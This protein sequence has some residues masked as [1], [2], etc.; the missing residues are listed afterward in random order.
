MESPGVIVGVTCDVGG[1]RLSGGPVPRS[2]VGRPTPASVTAAAPVASPMCMGQPHA[3]PGGQQL[4]LSLL[5]PHPRPLSVPLRPRLCVVC[6]CVC[7]SAG[8]PYRNRTYT[9]EYMS[10][11]SLP[12]PP[13]SRSCAGDAPPSSRE[14]TWP[15]PQPHSLR[16][17]GC[18]HLFPA[19]SHHLLHSGRLFPP[20]TGL[21]GDYVSTPSR[22]RRRPPEPVRSCALSAQDGPW[23]IVGPPQYLW[24]KQK[25]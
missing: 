6:A 24:H 17:P 4:T 12:L 5:G 2:S 25:E 13:C 10:L 16:D 7:V 3:S 19:T 23:Q 8:S 11:R 15:S 9:P 1:A 21:V 14:S 18:P 22:M 20:T